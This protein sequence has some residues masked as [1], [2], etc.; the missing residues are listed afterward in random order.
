MKYVKSFLFYNEEAHELR[1]NALKIALADELFYCYQNFGE[2]TNYNIDE[3]FE[4]ATRE[5]WNIDEK[6]QI[7]NDAIKLLKTNHNVDVTNFSELQF[8]NV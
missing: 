3:V 7:I 2:K 5:M 1:A 6:E 4:A 8:K